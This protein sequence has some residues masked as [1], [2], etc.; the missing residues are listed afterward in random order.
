MNRPGNR[1]GILTTQGCSTI[2]ILVAIGGL[3]LA[4]VN[5]EPVGLPAY[6][7][8][9]RLPAITGG[10]TL[11]VSSGWLKELRRQGYDP[12][13]QV[14]RP[15]RKRFDRILGLDH[16]DPF[17]LDFE[18]ADIAELDA[19]LK[20]NGLLR[21]PDLY[22]YAVGAVTPGGN[23][24]EKIEPLP[25][26]RS[27]ETLAKLHLSIPFFLAMIPWVRNRCRAFYQPSRSRRAAYQLGDLLLDHLTRPSNPRKPPRLTAHFY[28]RLTHG[29]RIEAARLLRDS[30]LPWAGGIT[31]VPP[32]VQ[33]LRGIGL[34]HL[35]REEQ[36][37]LSHSLRAE[38]LMVEPLN[39]VA[40]QLSMREAKVVLSIT[41]FGEICFR[42]A[43]AWA[44]RRILVCQDLS[45]VELRYPLQPGRNVVYCRPDLSDLVEILEDIECNYRRYA[46]IADQ[47]YE[48]WHTWTAGAREVLK[49]GYGPLYEAR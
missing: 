49:A 35:S 46:S 13:T 19:V 36:A 34:T 25:F 21:D 43:E 7:C 8:P 6:T 5:L 16:A 45:H 11:L 30:S 32:D 44:N 12:V 3:P 48:D 14:L 10:E 37:A 31:E 1:I 9:Y 29:Q 2:D 4:G 47:G 18:E 22:N 41:G 27:P 40:Y 38:G 17:L 24:T 26:T 42:Q 23:W 20:I 15:L 33:G 39:R 28:A